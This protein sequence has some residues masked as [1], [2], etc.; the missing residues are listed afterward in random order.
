MV[1][2]IE[3]SWKTHANDDSLA[4]E[5]D[6]ATIGV[7]GQGYVWNDRW[8]DTG[9]DED[10][11]PREKLSRCLGFLAQDAAVLRPDDEDDAYS[12]SD[13][14]DSE[15]GD[16]GDYEDETEDE[17]SRHYLEAEDTVHRG[18][19][20][21]HTVD[22]VVLELNALKMGIHFVSFSCE[23]NNSVSFSVQHDVSWFASGVY[24]RV[25]PARGHQIQGTLPKTCW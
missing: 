8:E 3:Y 23:S 12:I 16:D 1:H 9:D 24:P 2:I 7:E 11:D 5:F 20:E 18:I 25:A 19:N 17:L 6:T 15:S 22:N 21:N 14:L 10:E 4:G 13:G